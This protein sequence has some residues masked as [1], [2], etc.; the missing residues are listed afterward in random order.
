MSLH[1]TP[2][3]EFAFQSQSPADHYVISGVGG[4]HGDGSRF[5]LSRAGAKNKRP[6]I[7][8]RDFLS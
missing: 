3:S 4:G 5:N 2:L 7:A 6:I 1:F 8:S